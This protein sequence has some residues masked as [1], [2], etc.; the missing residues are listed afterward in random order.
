MPG[1][2]GIRGSEVIAGD[3]RVR[4]I[5]SRLRS[6]SAP[7][8]PKNTA[9]AS[10][11]RSHG[12]ARARCHQ[13]DGEGRFLA[14]TR[15]PGVTATEPGS[16]ADELPRRASEKRVATLLFPTCSELVLDRRSAG[17]RIA[18]TTA[19]PAPIS[20]DAPGVTPT[21]R[22]A[23][24]RARVCCAGRVTVRGSPRPEAV[25]DSAGLTGSTL[26]GG[27]GSCGATTLSSGV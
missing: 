23:V 5:G 16:D 3:S 22:V 18:E 2:S 10:S 24:A 26:T 6:P 11:R 4:M 13:G 14:A 8:R 7:S 25:R 15:A 20:K 19:S 21:S 27:D 1:S 9:T 17:T 12:A